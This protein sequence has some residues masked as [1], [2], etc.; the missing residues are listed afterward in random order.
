MVPV[1]SKTVK[2][3][4]YLLKD[5]GGITKY[6]HHVL[7]IP[8]AAQLLPTLGA[9][10][11]QWHRL[12]DP[13]DN[14]AEDEK[15]KMPEKEEEEEEAVEKEKEQQRAPSPRPAPATPEKKKISP[16]G[17]AESPASG[18]GSQTFLR[19][20]RAAAQGNWEPDDARTACFLCQSAFTWSK[21]RL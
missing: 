14:D 7:S 16:E 4:P 11:Q 15:K 20:N 13:A 10:A 8:G 21:R 9:F 17:R 6:V 18:S 3:T 2:Y 12:I 19:K 1:I 5:Y